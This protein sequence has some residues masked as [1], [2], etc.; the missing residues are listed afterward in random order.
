MEGREKWLTGTNDS[1]GAFYGGQRLRIN[2]FVEG[3]INPNTCGSDC[4]NAYDLSTSTTVFHRTCADC[5]GTKAEQFFVDPV[6]G[7]STNGTP[8]P[9]AYL[10][11]A[12]VLGQVGVG[13]DLSCCCYHKGCTDPDAT[14]YYL[15]NTGPHYNPLVCQSDNGT[16]IF[17]PE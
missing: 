5:A 11:V 8:T 1:T 10:S 3:L 17:D 12:R 13:A 2:N 15:K 9:G 7:Q 16:C 14:N 6:T 4:S